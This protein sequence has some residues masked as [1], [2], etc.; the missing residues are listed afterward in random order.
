MRDG[1]EVA[2]YILDYADENGISVTNLGLQKIIYFCHVWYLV[3]TNRPLIKQNFEAWEFGP[4]LPYLY[5]FFNEFGDTKITA[6]ATK[7]D[8][9]TGNRVIARINIGKAEESLLESIVSFYSRLS[10]TQLVEQSHV[11]GG[12]WHEVWYHETKVNPGMQIRNQDILNF[13]ASNE[14]LFTL[15]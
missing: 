11:S 12:P 3:S 2:N 13:Y 4:V 14:R 7:L 5:R 15:Q 10:V 8:H 6:R 9:K 1:R